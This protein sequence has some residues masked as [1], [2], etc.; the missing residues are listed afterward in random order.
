MT[1]EYRKNTKA[2]CNAIF[3]YRFLNQLL[4]LKPYKYPQQWRKKPLGIL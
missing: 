2:F 1:L 4:D 3:R